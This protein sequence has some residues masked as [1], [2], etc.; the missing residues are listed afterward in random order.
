MMSPAKVSV[1]LPYYKAGATLQ[2]AVNAIRAQTYPNWELLLVDN[3]STDNGPALARA[4]AAA[5]DRIRLLE[6]PRRGIVPALNRGLAAARGDSIARMDA[7]DWAAPARLARQVAAL[8]TAPALGLVGCGVTCAGEAAGPGYAHYVHWLNQ[9]TAPEAIARRRFMESPL[10]HPSVCFRS[11]L[12]ARWGGYRE[13]PFPEDYELWLRWLAAGVRMAKV[14]DPLLWWY[15]APQRLSRQGG[16]YSRAA[17]FRLKAWYLAQWLAHHN[18]HH[19]E[20]IVAGA[21][22]RARQ[23]LQPL[24]A[25]GIRVRAFVD[26]KRRRLPDAPCLLPAELPAPGEAFVVSYVNTRGSGARVRELLAHRGYQEGRDFLLAA[27]V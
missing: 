8:D 11:E 2:R 27:G 4:L 21:G 26:L 14:P 7:D 15:D 23:D 10:A 19:P 22:P 1:L 20:V 24:L 6:Q 5:E 3:G 18:P 9:L 16:R 25:A 13:G 17:F 12:V